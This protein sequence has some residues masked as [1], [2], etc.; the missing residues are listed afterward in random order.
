MQGP[1]GPGRL[2]VG[3]WGGALRLHDLDEVV[4]EAPSSER[5]KLGRRSATAPDLNP[6]TRL[7]SND[8]EMG[9]VGFRTKES[10]CP[11][12]TACLPRSVSPAAI[13]NRRLEVGWNGRGHAFGV[14]NDVF[15]G[16]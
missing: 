10:C 5:S 6:T 3:F 4:R 9:E 14:C 2:I 11:V 13:D 15:G 12:A 16:V 8:G 7:L 1:T